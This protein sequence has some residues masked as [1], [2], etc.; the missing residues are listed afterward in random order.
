MTFR[1][2]EKKTSNDLKKASL[3]DILITNQGASALGMF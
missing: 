3:P 1:F 2:K